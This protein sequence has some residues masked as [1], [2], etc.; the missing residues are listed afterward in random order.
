MKTTKLILAIVLLL[1]PVLLINSCKDDDDPA[2]PAPTLYFN[3][4]I[5]YNSTPP[6][7]YTSDEYNFEARVYPTGDDT[8]VFE[9]ERSADNS[10]MYFNLI[11]PDLY[12]FSAGDSIIIPYDINNNTTV[13][14]SL[15]INSVSTSIFQPGGGVDQGKVYIDEIDYSTKRLKGRVYGSFYSGNDTLKVSNGSFLIDL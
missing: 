9:G 8:L 14:C 1:A 6:Q 3:A 7:T 12:Q 4:A 10:Y 11:T 13:F 2:A 15:L 5:K